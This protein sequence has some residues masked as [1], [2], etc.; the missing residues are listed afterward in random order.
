[1]YFVGSGL[2]LGGHDGADGLAKLGVVILRSNL[3]FIDGVQVRVDDDDSED[4][5]LVIRT[6]Q[7][8]PGSGEML[9]VRQNLPRTLR[10]F[11]G[12]V[13]PALDLRARRQQLKCS[14][15]AVEYRHALNLL[16]REYGG[17]VGLFGL[18]LRYLTG[19]FNRLGH[20]ADLQLR[21]DANRTVDV[22]AGARDLVGLESSGLD[23][24][25]VSIRNKVRDA[26]TTILVG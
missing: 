14:E 17:D 3:H 26:V 5:V 4:G 23:V 25:L 13:T 24:N 22:N 21:I 18:K 10:V 2:G 20:G 16:R 12:G 1:M 11:A 15:V 6:I 7:L 9:S 8:K 19:D